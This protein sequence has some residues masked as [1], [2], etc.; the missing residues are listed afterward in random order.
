MFS[1]TLPAVLLF[2]ALACAAVRA[3]ELQINPNH[4]D[5]YT[6]V[7][8]DTL[9]DISG[10]FLQHPWQWPE[11]WRN[12][13]LIKDPHWIYPGDTLYFSYVNGAP[14]LSLTPPGG[15]E[16]VLPKVRESAVDRA[17]QMI[18]SDAI[19]QFLNSPKVVSAE[20]LQ[21]APYVIGFVGEH[22]IAGAGDGVYVR[23]ID[24]PQSLGYTV[25]RQGKPYV[26]PLSQEILGYE[27]QFVAD[28]TLQD[29]G[30][31]ATFAVNKSDTEIQR[32]DRLM[33]TAAGE[34]ALNYFPRPP[35]KRVVGSIIRVMG[36]VSQ[37][38]QHDVVVIDRG[39][40][41]GLEAGHTLDVYRRGQM[42]LDRYQSQQPVA[43]KMPDE[44]AGVLMVFRPFERVSYALV[45]KATAA[46][47]TLD[48][49]QTP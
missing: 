39:S 3:D 28:A 8:G 40:A 48:R 15:D 23:G 42:I 14:R 20:E 18:P 13:P 35:E 31:P 27:A 34:M 36:G 16:K 7:R 41:D 32:G 4:P 49:V 46:M 43:V 2:L 47:H 29:I 21:N 37:I 44:Q 24:E 45:M 6:V 11:L 12:N 10:R 33:P 38:G 1:R 26:D 22:L 25:F 19:V 9:W 30:D 5:Q 17:V